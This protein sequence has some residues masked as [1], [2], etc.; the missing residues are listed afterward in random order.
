[1][2]KLK[3]NE[4]L[5]NLSASLENYLETIAV[6][7]REKRYARIGT[8][9]K[10]LNVKSSSV[11]VA[12]KFLA[13]NNLVIHEKYGHVDLTT[14]GEALALEV[15]EKH[16]VLYDFLNKL[17]FVN[18]ETANQEACEM[19][20]AVS[21]ETVRKIEKLHLLLRECFLKNDEDML[22]LRKYLE[23]VNS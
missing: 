15:K 1:M 8:I 10:A 11:N 7:K 16:N 20:H 19:E 9:A 12:M 13:E 2:A 4:S 3:R 18:D 6:V 22:K 23:K 5:Y 14:R 17:L 21:I